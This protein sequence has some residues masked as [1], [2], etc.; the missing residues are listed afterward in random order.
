MHRRR[1]SHRITAACAGIAAAA[2]TMALLGS[3]ASAAGDEPPAYLGPPTISVVPLWKLNGPYYINNRGYPNVAQSIAVT[4]PMRLRAVA[5]HMSDRTTLL[6]PEGIRLIDTP[7][8]EQQATPEELQRVEITQFKRNYRIPTKLTTEVYRHDGPI[9]ASF[10]L[11]TG[12]LELVV[13]TTERR[14][15]KT[16]NPLVVEFDKRPLLRAGYYVVVFRFHDLPRKVL[17]LFISGREEGL[18]GR[19]QIYPWGRPYYAETSDPNLFNEGLFKYSGGPDTAWGEDKWC[20]GDLQ[21]WIFGDPAP[22]PG[23]KPKATTGLAPGPKPDV[24]RCWQPGSKPY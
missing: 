21:L 12:D 3:P 6:T 10:R 17:T 22:G 5:P 23:M 16:G 24:G 20:R 19:D 13:S 1:Q 18:K 9:P 7:G 11:D 2:C 14:V 8:W 4:K 15:I